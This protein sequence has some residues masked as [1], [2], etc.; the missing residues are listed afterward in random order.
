MQG[1]MPREGSMQG[2][3]PAAHTSPAGEKD[4]ASDAP[5]VNLALPGPDY[6]LPLP[7]MVTIVQKYK[8]PDMD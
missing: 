7:T 5:E 3:A 2:A 1:Y 6:S 4:M 8:S